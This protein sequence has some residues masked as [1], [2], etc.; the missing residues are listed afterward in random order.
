M[1]TTKIEIDK[2][3]NRHQIT[4][5]LYNL[6]FVNFNA[7]QILEIVDYAKLYKSFFIIKGKN[8]FVIER[9][10]DIADLIILKTAIKAG[11][12]VVLF[13][14]LEIIPLSINFIDSVL[15]HKFK[16]E[17]HDRKITPKE[18]L[19]MHEEMQRQNDFYFMAKVP[20]RKKTKSYLLR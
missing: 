8:Y 10:T 4:S 19:E 16:E 14:S 2:Y 11:K 9:Y 15:N 7:R 18:T 3:N 17:T 13:D 20:Y 6:N 1:N 5:A 12:K